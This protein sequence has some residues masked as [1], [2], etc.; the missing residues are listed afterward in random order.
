MPYNPKSRW[1]VL[2]HQGHCWEIALYRHYIR[3]CIRQL[4]VL[5]LVVIL[6]ACAAVKNGGDM[7]N[8]RFWEGGPFSGGDGA[9]LG[10]AEMTKG[11]YLEAEA[12]F[13]DALASNPRDVHALLGAAILYQNTGQLIRARELYEAILALRPDESLQFVNMNDISTRPVS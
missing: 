6:S 8:L 13:R 9:E 3:R 5:S 4:A 10:I 7:A 11:N 12:H 1:V 2:I